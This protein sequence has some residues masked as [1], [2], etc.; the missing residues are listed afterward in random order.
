VVSVPL[1]VAEAGPAKL[2]R[3]V[4]RDPFAATSAGPA[5]GRVLSIDASTRAMAARPVQSPARAG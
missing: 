1:D 4:K 3:T 2:T 5:G